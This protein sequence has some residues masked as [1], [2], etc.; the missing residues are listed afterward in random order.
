MPELEYIPTPER[1]YRDVDLQ[2]NRLLNALGVCNHHGYLS[3]PTVYLYYPP[4]VRGDMYT[5]AQM[6]LLGGEEGVLVNPGDVIICH[7]DSSSDSGHSAAP[8][9]TLLRGN[10]PP[11]QTFVKAVEN[12]TAGSFYVGA[13]Y[14][15][16]QITAY[17]VQPYREVGIFTENQNGVVN[18]ASSIPFSGLIV[19]TPLNLT[20]I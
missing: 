10:L 19:C 9:W 1:F 17:E 12:Q 3:S 14:A 16:M 11:F 15:L 2:G 20:F 5:I 7:A 8:N 18:W 6:K 4:A 13:N